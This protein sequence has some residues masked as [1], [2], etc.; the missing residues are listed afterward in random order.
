MGDEPSALDFPYYG[1]VTALT[2]RLF[3]HQFAYLNLY[4]NYASVAENSA[5]QTVN[6]LGTATYEEHIRRYCE[7]VGLD[8]LC[9]DF[10]M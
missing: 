4:P 2:E 6:Q 1:K 10:Y 3:P 7:N 5:S 9:Y 8:Y